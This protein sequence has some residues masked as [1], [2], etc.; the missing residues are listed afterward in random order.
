MCIHIH[1]AMRSYKTK[2][3]D[4]ELQNKQQVVKIII[5]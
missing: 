4:I 5:E 3:D 1:I 2:H